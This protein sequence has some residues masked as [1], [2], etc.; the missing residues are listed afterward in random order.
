MVLLINLLQHEIESEKRTQVSTFVQPLTTMSAEKNSI[1]FLYKM[2]EEQHVQAELIITKLAGGWQLI[3]KVA[4][5]CRVLTS[6]L[7]NI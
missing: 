2:I 3:P 4:L 1:L 6:L 7:H 5:S